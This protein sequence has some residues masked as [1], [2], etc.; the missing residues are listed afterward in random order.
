MSLVASLGRRWRQWRGL[1]SIYVQDGLA[2]PAVGAIWVLT[3][4]ATAITMPVVWIAA[5]GGGMIAGFTGGDFVLY[6]LCM[7]MLGSFITSHFMWDI[8]WEVKDGIFST[9]IIRPI[10]YLQFMLVRNFSWRCVRSL[11]FL[12]WF[13]VLLWVYQGW[14]TDVTLNVGWQFW[15]SVILGHLVSV[16]LVVALAMLALFTQE[17]QAIFELY[18]FPMLFLSGSLFPVSVL[19]EWAQTTAKLIPFYYTTGGPTEIL[20]GR[21]AGDGINQVL[22]MQLLWIGLSLLLYR[23]LF[24]FGMKHYTGV[25]M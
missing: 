24:R 20:I 3:D 15:L 21:V 10:S 23:F 18:Y 7:L 17:A 2:Y 6:Y 22:L 19:P 4:L 12:P 11:L 8:S 5:S 13:L 1:F 25:G 14:L 16:T 9:H